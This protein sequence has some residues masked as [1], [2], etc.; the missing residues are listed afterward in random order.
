MGSVTQKSRKA[1]KEIAG[2][3]CETRRVGR[4]PIGL[5]AW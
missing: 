2:K 3:A 1:Q 5:D 4:V